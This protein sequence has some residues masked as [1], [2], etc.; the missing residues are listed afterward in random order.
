VIWAEW[1]IQYNFEESGGLII[2][3]PSIP[4]CQSAVCVAV[5]R[6]I[7]SLFSIWFCYSYNWYMVH[8]SWVV[9]NW[10]ISRYV[11]TRAPPSRTRMCASPRGVCELGDLDP[12]QGGAKM[13]VFITAV[14]IMGWK[15][16]CLIRLFNASLYSP[17]ITHF[18]RLPDP[19][20]ELL[21]V[22]AS[23]AACLTGALAALLAGC[24]SSVA[25][26]LYHMRCFVKAPHVCVYYCRTYYKACAG[27]EGDSEDLKDMCYEVRRAEACVD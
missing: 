23:S 13:C 19:L 20:A 26:S 1:L 21:A 12:T 7:C 2:R 9:I 8:M 25:R 5:I 10:L 3:Q 18:C 27:G 16:V 22:C 6:S 11:R 4:Q 15:C 14:P 24:A 17:L